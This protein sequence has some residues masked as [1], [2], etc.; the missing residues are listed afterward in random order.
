MLFS[1]AKSRQNTR[2]QR[3]EKMIAKE[4]KKQRKR[5]IVSVLGDVFAVVAV[6]QCRPRRR[7]G[8]AFA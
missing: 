6:G 1:F 5:K 2:E 7:A 8:L 4:K 3:G